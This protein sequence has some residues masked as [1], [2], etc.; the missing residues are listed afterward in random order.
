MN[1]QVELEAKMQQ[2]LEEGSITIVNLSVPFESLVKAIQSLSV[3]D[4]KK[5]L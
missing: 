1:N 3:E 4:Q 5:L 2:N